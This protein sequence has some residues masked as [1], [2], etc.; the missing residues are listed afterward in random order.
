[1]QL[2]SE[3]HIN[4]ALAHASQA[5]NTPSEMT[6]GRVQHPQILV[7]KL[8]FS[9]IQANA[10][11]EV[12]GVV[13]REQAE[14]ACDLEYG[15]STTLS[16]KVIW[17]GLDLFD[18]TFV[19]NAG[20]VRTISIPQGYC[21]ECDVPSWCEIRDGLGQMVRFPVRGLVPNVD[22]N[23]TYSLS[24]KGKLFGTHTFSVSAGQ[25]DI[26]IPFGLGTV[27]FDG[28]PSGSQVRVNDVAVRKSYSVPVG[29]GQTV[30]ISVGVF[31]SKMTEYHTQTLQV[32]PNETI[33]FHVPP[34]PCT[35]E[36][37]QQSE[38]VRKKI[39][40]QDQKLSIFT[41]SSQLSLTRKMV[42]VGGIAGLIGLAWG[43]F[44]RS[45]DRQKPEDESLTHW[46]TKFPYLGEYVDQMKPISAG[47][48]QMGSTA[49]KFRDEM[50]V[51]K[52]RLSAFR[53]GATPVTVA[54]WK[55]YCDNAGMPPP[56]VPKWDVLQNHPVVYVSWND[57]M[58]TDGNGGFCAWARRVSGINLSVPTEAQFE[59]AARFS[60]NNKQYPW[61]G[62][63]DDSKLWSSVRSKRSSPLPVIR[64]SN[65]YQNGN[66]LS[67]M[68]GNVYQWC[69]DL[70]DKYPR[71]FQDNPIG[72]SKGSE[73]KRC[74]R[75]GSWYTGNPADFR[76]SSRLRL[77]PDLRSPSVGF[78]LVANP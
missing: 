67:D 33:T 54:L 62:T 60:T 9:D 2:L 56:K 4:D 49:K 24:Y 76:H 32:R 47:T 23:F 40:K 16:V 11:I 15:N 44:S 51:H 3:I 26:S 17:E 35:P 63:Y 53:M 1:L 41:A 38:R 43:V 34:G 22:L 42:I 70:Y 25:S 20:D 58:G 19:L 72:P 30:S 27:I 59:Y 7:T 39:T 50:P 8:L 31:D 52:V 75:G 12:N 37:R 71:D 74:A 61:P 66:G 36:P 29:L 21:V 55:E 13:M 69:Y 45:S 57:I 14:Y 46:Q 5:G 18:A 77:L 10:V 48:F 65:I 64:E 6:S 28:T 68:A 78:R 73:G